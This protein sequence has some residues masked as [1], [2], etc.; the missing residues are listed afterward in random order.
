[1]KIEQL[2][3]DPTTKYIGDGVYVRNDGYQIWLHVSDGE[4]VT[5]GIALDRNA[6]ASLTSYV[7][8]FFGKAANAQEGEA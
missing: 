6:S 5:P 4:S 2:R 8:R 7:T 1:M 3:E